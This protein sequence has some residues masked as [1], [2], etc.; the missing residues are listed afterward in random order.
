MGKHG[1]NPNRDVIYCIFHMFDANIGPA[2]WQTM[3]TKSGLAS[4]REKNTLKLTLSKA[5]SSHL[6][7]F[8]SQFDRISLMGKRVARLKTLMHS[9]SFLQCFEWKFVNMTMIVILFPILKDIASKK[10]VSLYSIVRALSYVIPVSGSAP[11][12]DKSFDYPQIAD[13]CQHVISLLMPLLSK[14]GC[15]HSDDEEEEEEAEEEDDDE[16]YDDND[17]TGADHDDDADG[18]D[19]LA[20]VERTANNSSLQVGLFGNRP[21]FHHLLHLPEI[22]AENNGFFY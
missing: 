12:P 19:A 7:S 3:I 21:V 10:I 20:K 16:N 17:A 13:L 8:R 4:A 22:I 5:G 1:Y 2:I 11:R 15:N 18:D 14:F 6:E 9:P